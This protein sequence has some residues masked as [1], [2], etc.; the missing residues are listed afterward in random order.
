MQNYQCL[1]RIYSPNNIL[2][3]A[4]QFSAVQEFL[5]DRKDIID[6]SIILLKIS[7]FCK[8]FTS[9]SEMDKKSK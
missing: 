1:S 8:R 4:S 2:F 6:I 5:T 3:V 7:K 9:L